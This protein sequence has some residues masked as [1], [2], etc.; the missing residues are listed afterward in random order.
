MTKLSIKLE[1]CYGIEKLEHV[2]DYSKHN[3]NLIYAPNGSMKTSL[4]NTFLQLS[5]ETSDERPNREL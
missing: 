5:Q 1:N 2:F 3:M 4:A